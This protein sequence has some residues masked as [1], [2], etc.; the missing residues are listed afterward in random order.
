MF[1]LFE[2]AVAME[3]IRR[4]EDGIFFLTSMNIDDVEGG[5]HV[6]FGG[7]DINA[8]QLQGRTSMTT[9]TADVRLG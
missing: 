4:L 2:R 9:A 5:V 8:W 7:D 1:W 3:W 6:A